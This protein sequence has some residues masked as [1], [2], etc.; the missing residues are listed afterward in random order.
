MTSFMASGGRKRR[1][2]GIICRGTS[3]IRKRPPPT[4]PPINLGIGYGRVLGGC[5][6]YERGT[7]VMYIFVASKSP[8]DFLST[9]CILQLCINFRLI[10]ER[11][12]WFINPTRQAGWGFL[13]GTQTQF[14][15]FTCRP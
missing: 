6:F 5:V 11:V 10:C 14:M 13:N 1:A 3:L 7:P 8:H 2:R 9:S 12:L 4:D 15:M